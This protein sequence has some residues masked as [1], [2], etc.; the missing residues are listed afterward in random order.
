ML[1]QAIDRLLP[2]V[3]PRLAKYALDVMRKR[4]LDVHLNAT[5]DRVDERS[6]RLNSGEIIEG[7]T[8]I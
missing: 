4:G 8:V 3:S 5:V 6:V 1:L 7:G 2:E